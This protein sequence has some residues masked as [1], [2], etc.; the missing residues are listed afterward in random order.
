MQQLTM[1][2]KGAR[3]KEMNLKENVFDFAM[4]F[5]FLT[6][7]PMILFLLLVEQQLTEFQN[8]K[9]TIVDLEMNY[10]SIKQQ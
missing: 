7:E 4:S 8:M 2:T 6:N 3:V 5:S 1:T 9:Q 10:N